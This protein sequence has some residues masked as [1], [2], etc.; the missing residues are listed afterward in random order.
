MIFYFI[1]LLTTALIVMI[2]NRRNE[3]N[4]WAA[5]FLSSASI[6]G[7]SDSFQNADFFV[8]ADILQFFNYTLTPYS[9]LIFSILYTRVS[10]SIQSKRKIK[11]W[12]LFPIAVMAVIVTLSTSKPLFFT[13]LLLWSAPYYLIS[14]FLLTVSFWKERDK[15]RKR[16]R[17]ITT[18]II[19]PTLLGVLIFIY[20]AKA[21][22]PDFEFFNYILVFIVY[23]LA[24][25]LLCTFVYGGA[26]R[27][28]PIRARSAGKHD[29]GR[30]YGHYDAQSYDQE[31]NRKNI[32]KHGKLVSNVSRN[33]RAVEAADANCNKRLQT[34]ARVSYKNP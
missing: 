11:L 8:T 15:R 19:V 27:E 23:S 21:V 6:G 22:S 10:L 29:E 3:T 1:A 30:Q 17:F 13:G 4:R 7:L 34:Y 20:V 26:R 28:A 18:I 9:V 2:N 24:L 33:R 32:D 14:C 16:N 25:A 12:L 5:Y 31:R